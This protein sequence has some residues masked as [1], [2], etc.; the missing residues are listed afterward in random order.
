MI[1]DESTL[2]GAEV[3]DSFVFEQRARP[4][5]WQP[6][7]ATPCCNECKIGFTFFTRRVSQNKK[8]TPSDSSDNHPFRRQ[9]TTHTK[10]HHC[11]ACGLQF[12][13]DCSRERITFP[14]E[15]GYQGP[16]RTCENCFVLLYARLGLRNSVGR[17]NRIQSAPAA[18]APDSS[19]S[20]S[21]VDHEKHIDGGKVV[22]EEHPEQPEK[23]IVPSEETEHSTK[24]GLAFNK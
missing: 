19:P 22:E 11:R 8:K 20:P 4:I 9:H 21:A 5:S 10:K 2:R 7:S 13:G 3:L 6:D 1:E 17:G 18:G 16:Q 24:E 14:P 15:Y 23:P 12:C